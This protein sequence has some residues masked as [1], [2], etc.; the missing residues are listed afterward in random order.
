MLVMVDKIE[1]PEDAEQNER[2]GHFQ[3]LARKLA[4]DIRR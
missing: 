2:N 3:A 4:L 1:I